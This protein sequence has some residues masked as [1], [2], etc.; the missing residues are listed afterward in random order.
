VQNCPNFRW[1]AGLRALSM[2][3]YI[4]NDYIYIVVNFDLV[5]DYACE[6]PTIH[7]ACFKYRARILYLMR[8]R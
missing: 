2:A 8:L 1:A 5:I 3:E 7:L 6:A 4:I